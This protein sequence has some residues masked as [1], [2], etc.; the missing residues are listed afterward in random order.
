[1]AA[2]KAYILITAEPEHTNA[3]RTKLKKL[4]GAKEV[5]EVMGPYDIVLELRAKDL[6]QVTDILRKSI[7]P[8][9]GVRNT[10]TCVAMN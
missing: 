9:P 8:L 3:L 7:R 5:H 6:A 2:I 1:M 4:K 10:V